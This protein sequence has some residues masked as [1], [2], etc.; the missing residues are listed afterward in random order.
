MTKRPLRVYVDTSVFG[1][2]F[3][4]EF[5]SAS[6]TFFGQ[7]LT[8]HFTL[9]LSALVRREL[10]AA[11]ETVRSLYE[12]MTPLAQTAEIDD[13]VLQLADAYI[14]AGIITPKS[15]DDARHVALTTVSECSAI[16]S[17]NFRHIVHFQKIPLYNAVNTV[18]G[19]REIAICSPGEVIIYENQE[20]V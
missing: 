11:P 9:V 19:Y 12:Q 4:A 7:V 2:M 5:R 8:G 3:D 13:E 17:W 15:I 10:S 1:G 18:H 6:G 16:V 14:G 20:E